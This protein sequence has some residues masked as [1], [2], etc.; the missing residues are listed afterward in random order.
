MTRVSEIEKL[1]AN[2]FSNFDDH[3][4]FKDMLERLHMH[5]CIKSCYEG[6][7]KSKCRC[8]KHFP[9]DVR[10]KPVVDN[11]HIYPATSSENVLHVEFT[12]RVAH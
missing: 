9:R 12:P 3:P 11:G 4:E 5:K 6:R 10:R 7:G 2:S 1:L 8:R